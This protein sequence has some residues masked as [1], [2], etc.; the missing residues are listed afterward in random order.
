MDEP[1]QV[2]LNEPYHTQSPVPDSKITLFLLGFC[3]LFSVHFNIENTGGTG[4]EMPYNAAV[5]SVISLLFSSMLFRL[6]KTRQWIDDSALKL[7]GLIMLALVIPIAFQEITETTQAGTRV[8]AILAGLLLTVLF[9]Q[10]IQ[11]HKSWQNV[12]YLLVAASLIEA[13]LCLVQQYFPSIAALGVYK[14]DY[15]RPFG[16]FQQPNV[17]ASF[18]ATGIITS[19]YLILK[20]H[21]ENTTKAKISLL[22]S[23]ATLG[24]AALIL[25]GS[26]TGIFGTVLAIVLCLPL[27][28]K[29]VTTQSEL[30]TPYKPRLFWGWLISASFG[31]LFA[32]I[33]I[34]QMESGGRNLE[35]FQ[36]TAN[37]T[38]IYLQALDMIKDKPL[39]GWGYGN[40]E[41]NFLD[42]YAEKYHSGE[43]THQI[44]ANLDH[45]H[46][47]LLLWAVEGGV[48]PPLLL[49]A[50]TVILI[51]RAIRHLGIVY[52]LAALSVLVPISF[53]AN[54]EYP[55]YQSIV[56]WL[57]LSLLTAWL[58]W[59][60]STSSIKCFKL[61]FFA[62]CF[63]VVIPLITIPVMMLCIQATYQ[64]TKYHASKQQHIE[65]LSDVIHPSGIWK[66]FFF[67]VMTYRLSQGLSQNKPDQI[68]AYISWAEEFLKHTPRLAIYF[69]LANAHWALKEYDQAIQILETA[70]Y[71]YP[72][73]KKLKT[74]IKQTKES[75]QAMSEVPLPH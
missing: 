55:F 68:K 52:G 1:T 69:N 13:L 41:R 4:L 42:Y 30:S 56:H 12:F 62:R 57:I 3:L 23:C 43:Y 58:L 48:I 14:E 34:Q 20:P 45:P 35:A 31:V 5:W 50:L 60:T 11:A 75:S 32:I 74:A 65:Y 18:I 6:A 28:Y 73:D 16:S 27:I 47:E 39:S 33:S 66:R 17:S 9:F 15:G 36:S 54:T 63:A 71:F 26:R 72:T 2:E 49:L 21:D 59:I 10:S 67:D 64:V 37:R 44:I 51:F 29:Y 19:L 25:L 24:S 46:N 53:H 40:F 61:D 38:G 70:A 8:L 22:L 7:L